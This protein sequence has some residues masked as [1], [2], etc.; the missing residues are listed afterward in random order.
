MPTK[1]PRLTINLDPPTYDALRRL[2]AVGGGSMSNIVTGFLS[3][4][5]PSMQ[6]MIVMMERANQAPIE[7]Q[8]GLA[9]AIA[10]VEAKVLPAMAVQLEQQDMFLDQVVREATAAAIAAAAAPVRAVRATEPATAR[11][12]P[13]PVTRGSGRAGVPLRVPSKGG[14]RGSL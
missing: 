11:P 2:S 10:A 5:V 4:C 14:R 6:R 8:Q 1:N 7:A 3:V 13:R 12:D 9:A